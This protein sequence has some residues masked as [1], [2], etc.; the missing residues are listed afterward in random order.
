MSAEWPVL[1]GPLAV[2]VLAFVADL[3]PAHPRQCCR[4]CRTW[5]LPAGAYL[6][7]WTCGTILTVALVEAGLGLYAL[8]AGWACTH[9]TGA[10][11]AWWRLR[12]RFPQTLP[13]RLPSLSLDAARAHLGRGVWISVSLIAQVL[14]YGTDLVVVS[15]LLGP[16]A[17]VPYAC[18]GRLVTILTNQPQLF[19]Q[20]ALPALSELRAS[21][22]RARMF[23]VSTSMSQLL[24]ISSGALACVV[25]A[26]TNRS[27]HGGSGPIAL[28]TPG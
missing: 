14:L 25:L 22:T 16:A 11:L 1:G 2:V 28:P 12:R 5:P 4:D 10:S 8:A 19:M 6:I 13:S 23:Q 9:I 18:T 7:A 24:L 15:V 26:S 3:S 27:S 17:V 20:T 21:A